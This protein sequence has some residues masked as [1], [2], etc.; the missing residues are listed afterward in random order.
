LPVGGLRL[1]GN[2]G[3]AD[4]FASCRGPDPQ[5]ARNACHPRGFVASVYFS[6]SHQ[7]SRF[8]LFR[9][10]CQPAGGAVI[11]EGFASDGATWA[12]PRLSDIARMIRA[13][14]PTDAA[15]HIRITDGVRAATHGAALWAYV[16]IQGLPQE[17]RSM[18][19]TGEFPRVT[20]ATMLAAATMI[21]HKGRMFMKSSTSQRRLA[22]YPRRKPLTVT[23]FF[24]D[25]AGIA[26]PTLLRSSARR[27]DLVAS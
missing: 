10:T 5:H 4:R 7:R 6:P 11:V 25:P 9:S 23:D 3:V 13:T 22:R 8:G 26:K 16:F 19:V 15:T 1:V 17:Y 2:S 20:K 27:T 14:I 12:L 24:S 18:L 21:S